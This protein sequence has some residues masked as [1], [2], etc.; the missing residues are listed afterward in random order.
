MILILIRALPLLNCLRL[1]KVLAIGNIAIQRC[2]Q[3][4]KE[5]EEW[6]KEKPEREKLKR[7]GDDFE[8]LK[9]H[10]DE[11]GRRAETI[12]NAK[13]YLANTKPYLNQYKGCIWKLR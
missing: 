7:V 12:I 2:Q 8:R 3:N 11:N 9:K 13:T 6:I 1:L 4:S 10:I 5:L